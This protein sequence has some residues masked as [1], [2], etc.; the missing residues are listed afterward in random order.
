MYKRAQQ[1]FQ[2]DLRLS[3]QLI[4]LTMGLSAMTAVNAQQD[5]YACIRLESFMDNYNRAVERCKDDFVS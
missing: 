3:M 5:P 2:H 4:L 1:S